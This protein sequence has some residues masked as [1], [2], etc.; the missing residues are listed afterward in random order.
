MGPSW[1]PSD[2]TAKC[3]DS[4]AVSARSCAQVFTVAPAQPFENQRH[5][6]DESGELVR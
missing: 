3:L 4:V 5:V 2:H 1:F 6:S